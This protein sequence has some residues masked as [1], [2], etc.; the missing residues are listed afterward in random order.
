MEAKN[1][2]ND[3]RGSHSIIHRSISSSLNERQA[4]LTEQQNWGCQCGSL[5]S[6]QFV[7]TS[8]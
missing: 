3:R 7:T 8:H 6:A 5:F 2:L 1:T 4:E